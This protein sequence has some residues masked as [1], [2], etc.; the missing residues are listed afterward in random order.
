MAS[1]W[2]R[3]FLQPGCFCLAYILPTT[4]LWINFLFV[5]LDPA[6]IPMY[7]MVLIDISYL[8][9]YKGKAL[10]RGMAVYSFAIEAMVRGY[11]VYQSIWDA[12]NDGED[13]ECCREVGNIH[14]PSAV[15]IRKDSVIVGHV[16]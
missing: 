5:L 16:P 4:L 11:H 2:P 7:V 3:T 6:G 1:D 12:A 9:K 8:G 14:D 10:L 13:L 15:A